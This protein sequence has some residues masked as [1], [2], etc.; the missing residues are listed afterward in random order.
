MD[1]IACVLEALM[2]YLSPLPEVQEQLRQELHENL[3]AAPELRS[4]AVIDSLPY[5]NACLQEALRLTETIESY[6]PRV[7]PAGGRSIEGYFLPEGTIVSSHP[8]FIN[9]NPEIFPDP[10]RFD[11]ERW[12]CSKDEYTQLNKALFT[13]SKG[14]YA[15]AGREIATSGRFSC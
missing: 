1:A 3:P 5:L 8:H 4:Y 6:Q 2:H 13:W 10:E 11:P 12:M 7:V 15:C 9:R 14:N